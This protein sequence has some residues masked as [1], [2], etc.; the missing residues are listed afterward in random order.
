MRRKEHDDARI[1][2]Y[3]GADKAAEVEILLAADARERPREAEDED[4]GGHRLEAPAKAVAEHVERN[5]AA[6]QIEQP[7]KDEGDEGTEDE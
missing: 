2:L 1:C 5:N 6:R 4:G 3:D 7:R